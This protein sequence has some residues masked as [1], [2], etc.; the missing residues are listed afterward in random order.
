MTAVVLPEG[1]T[2]SG[3][4]GGDT[5]PPDK[6]G[7]GARHDQSH[8]SPPPP[9]AHSSSITT[10]AW[11]GGAGAAGLPRKQR[12]FAEIMADQKKNRNILEI[13]L[14][15][16]QKEDDKGNIT[17]HRNL[18]FDEIATFL[19]DIL[20]IPHSACLR[21]NYTTGRY[22]SREVMFKP[23]I[24]ITP[25][26]GTHIF[27][28]HEII[29]KKQ[30]SSVT[31]VTFKNVPLNIPDEEIIHLCETYGRPMDYIVH[32]EKLFN[33]KNRGMVG[34]TRYVEVELFP[35]AS[36]NNYYW[37]EGPL[38]GDS[39]SRVTVLHPGQIQQCSNCLK[40][41]NQGCPGKGNGKACSSLNTPKTT[42]ATYMEFL[43]HKHGYH[44]L[45]AKYFEQY[46]AKGGAGNFGIEERTEDILGDEEDIVPINPIEEKDRQI[47]EL[48]KTLEGSKV[49]ESEI[50][51]LKES[52]LKTRKEL[53]IANQVSQVNSKKLLVVKQAVEQKMSSNLSNLSPDAEEE[54]V[55]LYS[56][57]L[58]EDTL[59]GEIDK[60]S[61]EEN[62]FKSVEEKLT[63]QGCSPSDLKRLEQVRDKVKQ[64]KQGRTKD[65]RHSI[66]SIGSTSSKRVSSEVTGGDPSRVKLDHGPAPPL[67][68][69]K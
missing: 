44:S 12:S 30:L 59:E 23:G 54:I 17:K 63:T 65:R 20:K 49:Q 47:E 40:V 69:P 22:D 41:A 50:S 24:D 58:D 48:K 14:T 15:K 18:T 7:G 21:F 52:L 16:I 4:S 29:T 32:Y 37:L 11:A 57:L 19:F 42:M 27:M 5:L 60:V 55:S 3:A 9:P 61:P 67:S 31:K 26:L 51:A 38:P 2:M 25:Y 1:S 8:V 35:G 13:T 28:E 36:M 43:K 10:S 33:N 46:P 66:C 34:S 45:K 53:K 6:G 68:L 62:F 39:G 56:T 64:N